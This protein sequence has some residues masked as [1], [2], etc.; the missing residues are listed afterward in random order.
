MLE[1][2]RYM[3]KMLNSKTTYIALDFAQNILSI[4]I[5]PSKLDYSNDCFCYKMLF[6]C[7]IGTLLEILGHMITS[8]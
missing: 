3:E 4:L 1:E 5:I 2:I 7:F 6:L 8:T